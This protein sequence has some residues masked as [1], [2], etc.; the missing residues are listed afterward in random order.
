MK[1]LWWHNLHTHWRQD[2]PWLWLLILSGLV[3]LGQWLVALRLGQTEHT[4]APLHYT[5]YFGTDLSLSPRSLL[6]IPGLG[7]LTVGIHL[8]SSLQVDQP[9]WRRTWALI[10][11]LFNVLL[12]AVVGTLFYISTT[13]AV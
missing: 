1:F 11:L 9:L 12:L 13:S 2:R 7:L 8:W 4:L 6:L 5:I 3:N 10:A